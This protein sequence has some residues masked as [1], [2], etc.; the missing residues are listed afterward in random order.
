VTET[1]VKLGW[2]GTAAEAEA[3]VRSRGFALHE[4]RTLEEDQLFDRASGELQAADQVLRLRRRGAHATVT[5]KG[6]A[7]RERYKSREEIEFD[8]SA[9]DS[10]L[11]VLDRLG[12]RPGFRYEKYRSKFTIS[13]EPGM[14]MIDETPV[15]IYI[16]LEGPGDWIDST[17]A[18]L[19]YTADDF[20]TTSY[21][22]LYRQF[23]ES[24]PQAPSDMVFL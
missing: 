22:A 6:P 5:Y 16:E 4:P 15:G 7:D 8:V 21:A 24:H 13:G 10:F 23:R 19:G 12:Y 9:A 17:A 11:V 14:I 2:S 3:L 20:L 18:R 1:E